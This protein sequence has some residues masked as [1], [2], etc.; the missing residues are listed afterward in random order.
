MSRIALM[1]ATAVAVFTLPSVVAAAQPVCTARSA[2]LAKLAHDFQE[3]PASAALTN[4]GHLLEV[5]K[6]D[7]D[8]TWSMLITA[9]SGTSCLVAAGEDWQDKSSPDKASSISDPTLPPL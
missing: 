6:S 5:L 1:T 8:A 9:P 4:D 7:N 3:Q 2:I